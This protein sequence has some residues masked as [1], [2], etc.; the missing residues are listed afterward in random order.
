MYSEYRIFI[1]NMLLN[2]LIF[3]MVHTPYNYEDVWM[4]TDQ[5]MFYFYAVLNYFDVFLSPVFLLVHCWSV[6]LQFVN[7]SPLRSLVWLLSYLVGWLVMKCIWSFY[8][9][10]LSYVTL[11]FSCVLHCERISSELVRPKAA[12]FSRIIVHDV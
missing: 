6:P 7:A 11:T 2:S 12:I 8:L 10:I 4:F 3:K 1:G 5:N 9:A